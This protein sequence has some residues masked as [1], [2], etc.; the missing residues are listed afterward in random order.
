MDRIYK[1][2]INI[3]SEQILELPVEAM[4]LTVTMQRGLVV[5]YALIDDSESE[6]ERRVI[7]IVG[8]GHPMVDDVPRNYLGTVSRGNRYLVWHVFERLECED[9]TSKAEGVI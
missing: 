7:E 2:D 1:Y 9:R 6:K 5:L 3:V 8:T 4:I